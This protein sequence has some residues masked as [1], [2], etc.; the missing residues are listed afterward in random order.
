AMAASRLVISA[1]GSPLVEGGNPGVDVHPDRLRLG[2]FAHRLEAHL[3]AV[4]GLAEAAEGRAGMDPLVAV[5]PD[6]AGVDAA[7]E[8]MGALKVPRPQPRAEPVA[9]VVGEG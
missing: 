9:G 7:G 1:I 4:A 5:D 8:A 6:H 2:V 3:A